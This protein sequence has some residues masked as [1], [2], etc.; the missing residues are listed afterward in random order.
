MTSVM[1]VDAMADPNTAPSAFAVLADVH[2]NAW[3]LREV[4]T[5]I[6]RRGIRSIFNLVGPLANPARVRRQ[7]VGVPTIECLKPV[8]EALLALGA[9]RALVVHGE[10]GSDEISLVGPTS[11]LEVRAGARTP[12]TRGARD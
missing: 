1:K 2:G 5:D 9:E 6:R 3:A 8:A 4:L 11:V 7:V 10:D 12:D